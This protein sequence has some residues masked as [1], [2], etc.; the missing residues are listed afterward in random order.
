MNCPICGH[1]IIHRNG[2]WANASIVDGVLVHKKCP[3]PKNVSAN[4]ES[5]R[6][7]K[8]RIKYHF[9]NNAKGY[10]EENGMNWYNVFRVIDVL[11][12]E[13]YSY[14]DQ[15]YAL[16]KVVLKQGGFYGYG[17]VRNNIDP[18]IAKKKQKE[19]IANQKTVEKTKDIKK[20]EK[21]EDDFEW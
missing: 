7:L 14:E 19:Q 20:W 17:S 11:Y 16:D 4:N 21:K 18:I 8:E 9:I 6:A 10:I 2:E 15:L 5:Y 13:G 1:R 12:N 3:K